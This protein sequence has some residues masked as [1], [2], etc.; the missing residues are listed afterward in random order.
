MLSLHKVAGLLAEEL[1]DELL[2]YDTKRHRAHCLNRTS[3]AVWRVC[4]GVASAR[5]ISDRLQRE[6]GV[7]LEE[8]LI[9]LATRQLKAAGL[10][11]GA[12]EDPKARPLTK[13]DA[14]LREAS[15]HTA[16]P[17]PAVRSIVVPTRPKPPPRSR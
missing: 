11:E 3:A 7:E 10:I 9:L 5:S 14:R 6:L 12:F 2:I 8:E 17:L 4:D 13:S 16:L 1:P 15:A